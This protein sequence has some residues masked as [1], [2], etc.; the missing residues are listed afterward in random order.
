MKVFW[1]KTEGNPQL[2]LLFNG[3]GFDG[4]IFGGIDI[5][6]CDIV[7]VYD[8]TNIA[9]EQF[10]FTKLYPEVTIA[11]WS[12]GVFVAGFY[13]EF[14][15]N[16]KKAVAINGSTSPIDDNKGIPVKIFLATMYS[17]NAANREKFY[18][19][20][21]GG[22]SAYKQIAGKLPDRNVGNQL[23]ELK[24][25]YKLSLENKDADMNWDTAIISTHDKIFPFANMQN[26]WGEKA[27]ALEGEHYPDFNNLL[28]K[29]VLN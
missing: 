3:W 14:I 19:R 16:V 24:S 22:L 17:F 26:A 21:A 28:E 9:P 7:S 2:L 23:D 10:G 6:A 13:S 18:L 11:A 27:V 15:F 4:K 29:Y 5:P 20:I 12:Y 8:Y 25:L 1:H